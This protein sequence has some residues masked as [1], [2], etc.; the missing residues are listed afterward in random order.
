MSTTSNNPENNDTLLST[1][2]APDEFVGQRAL[3]QKSLSRLKNVP[4]MQQQ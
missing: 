2:N 1:N 3:I 4:L